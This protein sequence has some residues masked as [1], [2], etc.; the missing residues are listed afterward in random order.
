M[1]FLSDKLD[2]G[3]N[4]SVTFVLTCHILYIKDTNAHKSAFS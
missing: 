3:E 1:N 4:L 2:N